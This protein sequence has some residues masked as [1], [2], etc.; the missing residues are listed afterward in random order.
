[1]NRDQIRGS[2]KDAAGRVQRKLGQ[3][4]GSHRQQADGISTQVDGKVN[5]ATGKVESAL[6]DTAKDTT[7]HSRR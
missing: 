7:G 1:M 5:K 3:M 2:I 4:T 6:D